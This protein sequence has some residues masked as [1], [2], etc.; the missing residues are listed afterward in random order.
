MHKITEKEFSALDL[1]DI[2]RNKRFTTILE[3]VINH[4]GQSIPQQNA[5]TY[6]TKA[7]YS[8]FKNKNIPLEKIQQAIHA[9]GAANIAADLDC[10]LVLHDSSIISYNNLQAEGLGYTRLG[11][12]GLLLHTSMATDT[13]GNPLALLY[14]Q[15]WARDRK[16]IGKAK[17]RRK[18]NIED[19]E[20]YKWIEGIEAS[21]TL[22]SNNITKV[23]VADREADVY[24]IF[25][26][27][28]EVNSELL[29]R[30]CRSRRIT[31]NEL[32]WNE[33]SSLKPAAGI[34]LQIPDVKGHKKIATKVEVRYKE[35]EIL[36]PKH[37]KSKYESVTLTAI[38]V[39]QPGINDDEQG[40]WWKLLTTLEVKDVEDVKKYILWYTYRWQIERFHFVIKSG[41]GIEDLQLKQAESLKKAIAIYSLAGFKIMQLT[42]QS[43]FTPDVSCEVVLTT[44]EWESLYL[45]MHKED[46]LPVTPPTL[47]QVAKWIGKLGGHLGRKSDGPPGLKTIWQ[48]YIRL[49]DFTDL[50]SRI[51]SRKNLGN[52]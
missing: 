6:D 23:H 24:E 20:S 4:P 11:G 7:T 40:I 30:A 47:G 35:V 29:I 18:K 39:R 43:R 5:S 27:Q 50:Y 17:D 3:N 8:F 48:G 10:I 15:I 2:R 26:C 22:I 13:N 16:E 46:S 37:R 19:K 36:C 1:G 38:E 45:R 51:K 34:V 25:F 31:G 21:N 41:C 33:V 32:L 42:Y 44:D 14:Q 12:R 28:P 52:D 9:Y 49:R